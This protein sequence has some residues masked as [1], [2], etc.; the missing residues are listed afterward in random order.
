MALSLST[1]CDQPVYLASSKRASRKRLP[2]G[3][4]IDPVLSAID[5]S[6]V[7]HH[8][9]HTAV[10]PLSGH[11]DGLFRE[12]RQQAV[13]EFPPSKQRRCSLTQVITASPEV[14]RPRLP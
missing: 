12:F 8:I 5:V 3:H 14:L 6:P 10:E 11:V 4:S 7:T 1:V 9:T 2:A 13:R